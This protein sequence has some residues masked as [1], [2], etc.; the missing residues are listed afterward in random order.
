MKSNRKKIKS[1]F[2]STPQP[3]DYFYPPKWNINDKVK[4]TLAQKLPNIEV[5]NQQIL[6]LQ[7]TQT[8]KTILKLKKVNDSRHHQLS[9]E[10]TIIENLL[11]PVAANKSKVI[12]DALIPDKKSEI[13]TQ[14]KSKNSKNKKPKLLQNIDLEQPQQMCLF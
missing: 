2:T 11:A 7:T 1:K 4:E 6:E 8:Q 13:E 14:Y 3:I 9:L 12:E 5:H 10:D